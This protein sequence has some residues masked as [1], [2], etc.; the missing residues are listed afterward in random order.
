MVFY[1]TSVPYP[2]TLFN[3]QNDRYTRKAV[4]KALTIKYLWQFMT[5]I[6]AILT[7]KQHSGLRTS[8]KQDIVSYGQIVRYMRR[9]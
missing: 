4:L 1:F 2:G 7:V 6:T 9:L 5:S 8:G 3:G